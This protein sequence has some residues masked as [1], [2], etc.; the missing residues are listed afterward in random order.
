MK[1]R[2]LWRGWGIAVAISVALLA[3]PLRITLIRLGIIALGAIAWFGFLFLEWRRVWL[4]ITIAALTLLLAGLILLPSHSRIDP[5][6]LRRIYVQQLRNYDKTIYV[7]GGE[8]RL[9]IDCSGLVRAAMVQALRNYGIKAHDSTTLRSSFH[10][11]W[12][13]SSATDLGKAHSRDTIQIGNGD[14][15]KLS[16]HETILPGD[17]AVTESGSHVLAYLGDETWIEAEPSVGR[18]HIFTLSGQFAP[19]AG[20]QVRFVRWRWLTEEKI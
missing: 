6:E 12:F 7:Y 1:R 14:F 20:E 2:Y 19:L 9:G 4:R 16:D 11:W 8:T 3:C 5:V 13:D 18:T 15:A 10:L 17:L